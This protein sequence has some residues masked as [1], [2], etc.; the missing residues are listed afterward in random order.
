MRV[1]IG[2]GSTFASY[3]VEALVGRGGMGVVYRATDLALERRVALKLIA[4]ELADD[5]R[6]RGRFLKESRL[7]ASLDHP[8]VIPIY[9]AGERDGQL[10][11][12]MRYVEGS[13]LKTMLERERERKLAPERALRVLAQIAGALDAAHRRGLVHRDVKPA[14][15]LLDEDEH[16]YLTDFGI[17]KHLGRPSTDT[18]QMVGTLDYLAPE[19]IRGD[20]VDGRSDCYAL[21]CVL[22]ECLAGAPPFQRESE[23]ETLWAHLQG[24]PAP[25]R[26][27]GALDPVLRKGLAKDKDE[28]PTSCAELIHAAQAALGLATPAAAVPAVVRGLLRRHRAILA[29]ALL[30]LAAA[31]AAIVALTGGDGHARRAPV[32]NGVAVID[33]AGGEVASF[34]ESPSPP[35]NVAVGAGAVWVLNTQDK[36]VSRL[37]PQ[38]R[39]ITRRLRTP[40]VPTD[41]A[42]GEGALWIGNGGVAADL[43]GNY[44]VSISR[45]DPKTGSITRTVKLPDRPGGALIATFN[46]GFPDIAVGAGAVWALNPDHT[47]S[48]IDPDTGKLVATID[49]DADKIAAGREGIWFLKESVVTQIDPRTNRVGQKIRIGTRAGTAIAV[50]AGKIWVTA[51]QEGVVWRIE[52][53]PSPVTRTIDVGVGV[54]YITFGAG[55]VWTANYVDGTVARIDPHTNEVTARVPIG[56]AQ[57]LAAGDGSAWVSTAGRSRGGT[58]PASSCGELIPVGK[59]PDLLIASDLPLQGPAGAGPRANAD[60]IRLVLR[61]HGFRAGR[62]TVGYRSCDDSTAQTGNFENRQCAANANAYA[63]AEKLVAVIG[64]QNSYCAQ[65]EIPTLNRAPGGPLAMI[66]PTNSYAGLTRSGGLPPPNGYRGEPEVYYPTGV[67][68]YLRLLPGD[69]LLAVADA[70]LARR[71]GLQS[72]YVVDDGSDFGKGLVADPFRR[73]A[74][75]LKLPVAGSATFDPSAASYASLANRIARSGAEGVVVGGSPFQGGD[76]LLKA[77]RARLGARATIMAGFFFAAPVPEVLKRAGSAAHGVYVA[78]NDLPRGVLPLT[79][80]GRRFARDVGTAATQALGVMEAGQAAELVLNAIA[81]SDGTRA[82]VLTKLRASQVKDGILGSFRFDRNGDITTASIPILRITGATPPST[83]LPSAFQ[84]A[85]VD[86]VVKLPASLAH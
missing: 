26:G 49:V 67:R 74:K 39:T 57:A 11:L 70:V 23:A 20:A 13:D 40:G 21:A 16:A 84:G 27:Y 75:N 83:P 32:G 85:V 55:A 2:P 25:L 30:V 60:A 66:S 76:R 14:N 24:E 18:G 56:A 59:K 45:I 17:S 52:P 19:Q 79:A 35:S 78:T 29:A 58:L 77:L 64:P 47:V 4:P 31:V 68:N 6:F 44:T 69:D 36:T 63:Q 48:R 86:T 15:V 3:R 12:A 73:A 38:T 53:G 41:I 82:S 28:R 50:G 1:A 80:A 22:Y 51:Q 5:E 65:I 7:A 54:T 46:W 61:Q 72:V 71:L 81:H 62:Y 37:D 10:Y 43:T 9:D 42:A 8:N 33:P 34:I